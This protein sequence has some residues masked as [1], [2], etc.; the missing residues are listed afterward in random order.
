M[1]GPSR[2]NPD[3]SQVG[4]ARVFGADIA[5]GR[6][7]QNG[8]DG[9]GN[10]LYDIVASSQINPQNRV[11]MAGVVPERWYAGVKVLQENPDGA[12]CW[13]LR[14]PWANGTDDTGWFWVVLGERIDW[15]DC[16]GN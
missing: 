9:D 8:T 2:T 7:V 13:G 6:A 15:R 3:T 10:P 16:E 5:H 4:A 14:S 1:S 11:E 12:P